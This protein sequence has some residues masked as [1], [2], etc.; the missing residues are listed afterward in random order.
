MD[1]R[2][3]S[4]KQIAVLIDLENVGLDSIE[5]VFKEI[6]RDGRVIVKRA[7]ADWSRANKSRDKILELGIE[8]IQLFRSAT[9]RKNA[10]DILL[11]IDAID[12]LHMSPI[13]VFVI[14][15]SDSDFI[16][17]INRLRSSGKLVFVAGAQSKGSPSLIKACDRYIPIDQNKDTIE[18]EKMP[19]PIKVEEQENKLKPE[20]LVNK[21]SEE[22]WEKIDSA[23]SKK[24]ALKGQSIPGPN[25]A[26]EAAKLLGVSKLSASPYK[27]LQGILNTSQFLS[28][29]WKRDKNTIIRR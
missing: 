10:N 22:P 2:Q 24:A 27:T 19:S 8:P 17:L 21:S 1:N 11:A 3:T 4:E 28:E 12:L 6:S 5:H 18:R 25:A 16:P 29:K 15:S 20:L 9:G 13:D 26:S 23:W 7:Y 14:V